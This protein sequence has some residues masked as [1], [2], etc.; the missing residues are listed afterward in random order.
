MD[1]KYSWIMYCRFLNVYVIEFE[2]KEQFCAMPSVTR[3]YSL[4]IPTDFS[5]SIY[6]LNVG[7]KGPLV[8][9][10][11]DHGLLI[12]NWQ[13]RSGLRLC[14]HPDSHSD[15]NVCCYGFKLF[16][17]S[18]NVGVDRLQMDTLLSSNPSASC[19]REAATSSE[20][21]SDLHPSSPLSLCITCL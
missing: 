21:P 16:V 12:T 4:L 9:I 13:E 8:V 6:T 17:F 15:D 20:Q 10:S 11:G 2:P 18:T 5:L 19:S 14:F 3:V 1:N 7:L